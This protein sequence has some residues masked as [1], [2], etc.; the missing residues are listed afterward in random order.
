MIAFP[1]PK[2][3]QKVKKPIKRIRK[4]PLKT[5]ERKAWD[6]FAR[7]VKRRDAKL[8]G[9][10]ALDWLKCYTCRKD[11]LVTESHA[12]H[13][14]H[15]RNIV[16]FNEKVVHGQCNKCNTYLRGNLAEYT[17]HMIEDYGREE[18]SRLL[19]LKVQTHVFTR[20]ELEGIIKKYT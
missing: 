13:F 10:I 5:L 1:K 7:W 6:V 14:I 19:S 2:K 15:N 11:I 18:V 12:G 3:K 4:T 16:R 8:S 17:I 9:S 20:E